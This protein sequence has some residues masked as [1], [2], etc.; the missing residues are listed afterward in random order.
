[1]YVNDP[2]N[3]VSQQTKMEICANVDVVEP[4]G[5]KDEDVY[6]C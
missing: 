5:S 1:M 6:R 3:L 4:D 2:L